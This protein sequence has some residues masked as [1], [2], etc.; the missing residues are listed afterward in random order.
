MRGQLLLAL[1]MPVW[2][3]KF[4]APGRELVPDWQFKGQQQLAPRLCCSPF[5][6]GGD[7]SCPPPQSLIWVPQLPGRG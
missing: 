4:W 6:N 7:I 3:K 2:P 1:E 5:S